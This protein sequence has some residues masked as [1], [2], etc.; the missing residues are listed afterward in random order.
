MLI[1]CCHC[2][3]KKER[4]SSSEVSSEGPPSEDSGSVDS[5][6]AST[7]AESV[8]YSTDSPVC[9]DDAC[10]GGVVARRYKITFVFGSADGC[11]SFYNGKFIVE[12]GY[13]FFGNTGTIETNEGC[14][15]SSLQFQYIDEE[16]GEPVFTGTP[17]IYFQDGI[18]CVEP[19]GALVTMG[20]SGSNISVAFFS[21]PSFSVVYRVTT[22]VPINCLGILTLPIISGM[23]TRDSFVHIITGVLSNG[24]AC[25]ATITVEPI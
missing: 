18:D 15:W 20:V 19:G 3:E 5:G 1:G 16:T 25:P 2:D 23:R 12:N 8:S 4:P 9:A 11:G 17:G 7:S 21:G 10:N 24:G 6:S 22:T 14:V 13:D